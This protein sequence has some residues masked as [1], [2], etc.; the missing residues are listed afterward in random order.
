MVTAL[1]VAETDIQYGDLRPAG[2]YAGQ[3]L[4]GVGRLADDLDAVLGFQQVA[5]AA[6]YDFVVVQDEDAYGGRGLRR[7]RAQWGGAQWGVRE[8]IHIM[9]DRFGERAGTS[10]C[11]S[12]GLFPPGCQGMANGVRTGP[13][14]P[15]TGG[16]SAGM[17]RC[18]TDAAKIVRAPRTSPSG[19]P[20][21]LHRGVI[22]P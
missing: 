6:P 12:A 7:G 8:L 14:G 21:A 16:R 18:H 20:T 5:Y 9:L 19:H 2:R 1:V 22:G 11:R 17:T 4:P 3:R 13:K 10:M 15:V